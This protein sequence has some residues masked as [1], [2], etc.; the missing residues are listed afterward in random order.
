M[1]R[2]LLQEIAATHTPESLVEQLRSLPGLPRRLVSPKQSE[3]GNCFAA[4][5]IV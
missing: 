4:K 1:M 5:F 3:G 2:P